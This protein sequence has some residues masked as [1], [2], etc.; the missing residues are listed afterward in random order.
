MMLQFFDPKDM[1]SVV[2]NWEE[3][4]CDLIR[5]LHDEVASAP[6]DTNARDL[7]EAL[8]RYPGIPSPW[9]DRDLNADPPPLLTVE[10]RKDGQ[11]LRFFSTI[12]TFG[13]ANDVTLDELRIECAFPGDEATAA[14]CRALAEEAFRVE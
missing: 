1:R 13:T 11:H 5:H 8:L 2:A 7:L 14:H 10:F 4:A 6:S 12:T 9:R 3:V